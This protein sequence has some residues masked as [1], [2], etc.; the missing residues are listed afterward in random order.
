MNMWQGRVIAGAAGLLFAGAF[1]PLPASWP[2]PLASS[3]ALAILF[4]TVYRR[5]VRESALRGFLFG[6]AGYSVLLAWVFHSLHFYGGIPSVLSL[7]ALLV[8]I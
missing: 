2:G 3:L 1:F 6:L 8:Q 4:L 5:D 7:A